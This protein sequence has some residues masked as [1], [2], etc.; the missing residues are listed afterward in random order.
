MVERERAEGSRKAEKKKEKLP[1]IEK[2]NLYSKGRRK[3]E[4]EKY[5]R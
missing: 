5:P 4:E 3:T 2:Y 1:G